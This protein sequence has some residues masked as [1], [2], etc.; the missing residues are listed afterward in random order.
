[1]AIEVGKLSPIVD[2]DP[3]LAD[4]WRGKIQQLDKGELRS[5]PFG[6]GLGNGGGN[7]PG[8]P[9]PTKR[10]Q[11]SDIVKPITF[12]LYEDASGMQK[13]KAKIRIYN[14]SGESI[15]RF[16]VAHTLSDNQGGRA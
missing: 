14:S 16:A 11:L 1:M 3:R 10:P 12:E 8:D 9:D 15:D 13:V 2:D 7:N 5:F 6:S 4:V